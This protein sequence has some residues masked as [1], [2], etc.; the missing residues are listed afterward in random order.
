MQAKHEQCKARRSRLE[1]EI[2]ALQGTILELEQASRTDEQDLRAAEVAV[3]SRQ[4]ALEREEERLRELQ[5]ALFELG[6]RKK[7]SRPAK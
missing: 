1:E 3:A 2:E 4:A 7:P 5:D 6:E